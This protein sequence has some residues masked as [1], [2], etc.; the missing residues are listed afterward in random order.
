MMSDDLAAFAA[1][2][3]LLEAERTELLR[4]FESRHWAAGE[5]IFLR[6]DEDS[7]LLALTSGAVRLSIAS[8]QGRELVLRH[9]GPGET[10]GEIA[11]IDGLPR[12]ADATAVAP[13][14]ALVL[15]RARF[16]DI[17]AEHAA[18]PLAMAVY[19]CSHL[20]NT[21]HQMESI[22]LY[23]LQ[24]RLVRF[25]ILSLRQAHGDDIPQFVPLTLGLNQSDLSAMLGAS[26]PKVNQALQSLILTGAL[27]RD[28]PVLICNRD[29]LQR[30]LD[31]VEAG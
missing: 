27:R 2:S 29:L 8:P 18:V 5:V 22:A 17:C 3:G 12:S 25:L 21:N 23:D 30:L 15:R 7:Y 4:A 19:L 11:L 1:F 31:E 14:T 20:R 6:G 26:R 10:L 9:V 24:S 13:T 16:L 28:G